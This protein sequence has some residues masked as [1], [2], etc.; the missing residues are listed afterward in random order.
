MA[1]LKN[2]IRY[3]YVQTATKIRDLKT[4][5]YRATVHEKYAYRS[6]DMKTFTN[7]RPPEHLMSAGWTYGKIKFERVESHMSPRHALWRQYRETKRR[8]TL[9]LAAG[10][11]LKASGET[12]LKKPEVSSLI[13][14][15]IFRSQAGTVIRFGGGGSGNRAR[16]GTWS[17]VSGPSEPQ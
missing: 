1:T 12:E 6:P 16:G 17:S 8:A 9:L 2:V 4:Q 10:I 15:R 3:E 7:T 13:S 5:A 11:I 14:Q